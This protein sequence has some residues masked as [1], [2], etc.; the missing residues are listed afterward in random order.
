MRDTTDWVVRQVGPDVASW[1]ASGLQ[2]GLPVYGANAGKHL[3]KALRGHIVSGAAATLILSSGDLIEL[4]RGRMSAGQVT[5][6]LARTGAGVAGGSAGWLLG[7]AAGA[8]LGSAI[9]WIG[10]DAGRL[11]GGLA[12]SILG[13]TGA[14]NFAGAILDR[15]IED[16][17]NQ[18][19]SIVEAAFGELAQRHLLGP[20]E[21]KEVIDRLMG[22]DDLPVKLRDMYASDD[23]FQF[24]EEWLCPL[25]E[26]QARQ[27][28]RIVLPTGNEL[29]ERIRG[30][31]ASLNGPRRAGAIP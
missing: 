12:G 5:K 21:A 18:M 20:Q 2:S 1:L 15:L 14:S 13:A 30:A 29:L 9:R 11:V 26:Q 3:S 31:G 7:S 24:A 6:N 19:A 16:D 22:T 27:R 17:A 4:I 23:P 8:S 25:I 10:P 28:E